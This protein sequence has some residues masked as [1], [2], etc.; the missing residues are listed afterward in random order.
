MD[1]AERTTE[2][3]KVDSNVSRSKGDGGKDGETGGME[4]L[5]GNVEKEA[6]S[7]GENGTERQKGR[8]EGR[9][10]YL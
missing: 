5:E 4:G 2:A 10:T 8:K 1:S 7:E 3:K 9:Q 6:G